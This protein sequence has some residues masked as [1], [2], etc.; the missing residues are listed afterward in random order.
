MER[1][2]QVMVFLLLI[3]S[4]ALVFGA[5]AQAK[6]YTVQGQASASSMLAD[7]CVARPLGAI[8]TVAGTAVFIVSLPFSALG[9]NVS[10]AWDEM[11]ISPAK[12]T[13][14]RPLGVFIKQPKPLL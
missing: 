14:L 10:T 13:F 9:H 12:Y 1:F 7:I 3:S 11:V 8:S 2:K 6:E 5:T 4:I